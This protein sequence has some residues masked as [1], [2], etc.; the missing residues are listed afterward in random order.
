MLLNKNTK[1]K[2]RSPDGVIDFF[3]IVVGVLQGDTLVPYLFIISLNYVFRL[4]I[5]LMK[6]NGLTLAKKRSR[7]YPAQII[8]DAVNEG[9]THKQRF[10]M[11]PFIRICK[12]WTTNK[13]L[14]TTAPYGHRM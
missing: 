3:D 10:P 9:R 2:V 13:N 11:E 12:C 1:I 6:E 7:Q 14:S 4:S 8:T 5:D